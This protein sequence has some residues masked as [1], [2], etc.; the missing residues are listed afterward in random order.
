MAFFL[1]LEDRFS[2]VDLDSPIFPWVEF[3]E[4]FSSPIN[5]FINLFPIWTCTPT[6]VSHL[7]AVS[8]STLTIV[9]ERKVSCQLCVQQV[10][11]RAHTLPLKARRK[12]PQSE[13]AETV[14]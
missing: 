8:V 5:E 4:V 11:I 14:A 9:L 2:P 6:V 1:N 7:Q 12:R 3:R 10:W 13:R